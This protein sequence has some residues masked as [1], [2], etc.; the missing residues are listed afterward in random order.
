STGSRSVA[1]TVICCISCW[2]LILDEELISSRGNVWYRAVVAQT[3]FREV[4]SLVSLEVIT[5]TLHDISSLLIGIVCILY[6]NRR[7]ARRDYRP[8]A[9]HYRTGPQKMLDGRK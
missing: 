7:K 5:D 3:W 4:D 2:K 9:G 6:H 8:S 1:C